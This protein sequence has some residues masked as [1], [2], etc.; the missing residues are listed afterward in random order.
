MRNVFMEQPYTAILQ[1]SIMH[2]KCGWIWCVVSIK[3]TQEKQK[4]KTDGAGYDLA[5]NQHSMAN[6]DKSLQIAPGQIKT[7]SCTKSE[8]SP[9]FKS[10]NKLVEDARFFGRKWA[11]LSS[12]QYIFFS[13]C[14]IFYLFSWIMT[15]HPCTI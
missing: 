4:N 10:V 12:V 3:S 1:Q 11:S 8:K 2:E 14:A 13:G 7:I 6:L 15:I 9:K 5:S